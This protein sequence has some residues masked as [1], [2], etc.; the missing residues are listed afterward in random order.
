M[1]SLGRSFCL[2]QCT[3][4]VQSKVQEKPV[5]IRTSTDIFDNLIVWLNNLHLVLQISNLRG[6]KK[7]HV[8]KRKHWF[9]CSSW[10]PDKTF[11]NFL[12][13]GSLWGKCFYGP[14]VILLRSGTVLGHRSKLAVLYPAVLMSPWAKSQILTPTSCIQWFF[15]AITGVRGYDAIFVHL[16][17]PLWSYYVSREEGIR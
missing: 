7:S 5:W 11:T 14:Q 9:L 2:Q 3:K 13:N 10:Y 12:L 6:L 4:E 15:P 17:I 1:Y 16:W 8:K